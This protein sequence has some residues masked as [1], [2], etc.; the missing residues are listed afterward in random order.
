MPRILYMEDIENGDIDVKALVTWE[1]KQ[2]SLGHTLSGHDYYI[3]RNALKNVLFPTNLCG[4]QTPKG[5][6]S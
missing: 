4:P 6:V 2:S 1:Y 5:C 3:P